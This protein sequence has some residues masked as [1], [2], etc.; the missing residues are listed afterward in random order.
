MATNTASA[1]TRIR[2]IVFAL[3]CSTSWLLYL[4]RYAFALIKPKLTTEW[5]LGSSELGLLDFAF[6]TC[7]MVFQIPAG[8]LADFAGVHLVLTGLIL[9]WSAALAMHAWAP[10]VGA[11]WWARSLL[12]VGQSGAFASLNRMTRDWFP[13][14]VRAT[15][16]GFVGVLSGRLGGVSANLLIASLM[17]GVLG[18]SWRSA[19]YA[20]ASLGVIQ[21]AAM[22][23]LYRNS[24]REHPWVNESE[25]ALIEG[26]AAAPSDQGSSKVSIWAAVRTASPRSILNLLALNVQS[27]L[28]TV[29]DNVYSNWIPLFLFQVHDLKFK[30]MGI[31]SALPLLGGAL[32]GAA[33]GWL[34]DFFIARTGNL[35]W[36]RSGVALTGKGLAGGLLAFAILYAY[37]DPY[38]FCWMLFLVK[39]VGDWSLTTSWATVSDIGGPATASVFAFNNSVAG[40]GAIFAPAM[41]GY[42]AEYYEWRTVFLIAC[43]CYL[44]CALSW[45]VVNCTIPIFRDDVKEPSK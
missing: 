41:Y 33:G 1:P 11:L 20:F 35:R 29:A 34:N 44:L 38:L 21:A 45:L 19:V 7:Y 27:V 14:G 30:E 31:Y 28:S 12:G 15:V 4:H 16:Q 22:F 26:D 23:L 25:R 18:M 24:P 9:I 8:L 2:W 32:G 43:A 17:I 37:D 3:G 13:L 39:F 5:G 42:V 40:V 36:S 6:S 10:N